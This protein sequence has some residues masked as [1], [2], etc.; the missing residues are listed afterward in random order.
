M[1]QQTIDG[2]R[3]PAYKLTIEL[4]S[5]PLKPE[6][7]LLLELRTY[8]AHGECQRA[9]AYSIVGLEA[10]YVPTISQAI[11]EGYLYG[12]SWEAPFTAARRQHAIARRGRLTYETETAARRAP[13]KGKR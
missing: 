9:Q 2:T 7:P 3:P 8:G 10:D 1:P 12:D 6:G 13:S 5:N 4:R 11:V